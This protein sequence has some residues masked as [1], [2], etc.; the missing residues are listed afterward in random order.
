MARKEGDWIVGLTPA[1]SG[2]RIVYFMRVDEILGIDGYWLGAR[3]RR[4]KPRFGVGVECKTGDNIYKP[5]GGGRFSQLPSSHSTP[6]LRS[7]NS[8]RR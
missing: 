8:A 6:P 2:N 3:C 4:K 7:T 5:S 1:A